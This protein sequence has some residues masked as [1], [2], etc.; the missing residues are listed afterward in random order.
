MNKKN[1]PSIVI[2][3]GD[4]LKEAALYFDEVVFSP[5]DLR[6]F[7]V[8]EKDGVYDMWPVKDLLPVCIKSNRAGADYY[9]K[10]VIPAYFAISEATARKES[11]TEVKKIFFTYFHEFF[12]LCDLC[13][14]LKQAPFLNSDN[15]KPDLSGEVEEYLVSL[16]DFSLVN[17]DR[18][19][20][21]QIFEFRNDEASVQKLR[22]LRLFFLKEY[23]G[24]TQAFLEDDLLTRLEDYQQAVRDWGFE[25]R[26]M[27]IS[28]LLSSKNLLGSAS[29]SLLAVL[30]GPEW[31]ALTSA[32]TGV[33]IELGKISIGLAKRR[34]SFEKFRREH[35]LSYI[36]KAKEKLSK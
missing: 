11:M 6:A 9:Y 10:K 3:L 30:F 1:Q 24:C 2:A 31:M 15:N 32:A 23:K 16:V 22:R 5:L 28:S 12:R 19:T 34:Y 8:F 14:E 20:W 26:T 27:T 36:I 4:N 29:A 35:P 17:T 21:E 18:A 13:P 33:S 7:R 25:T